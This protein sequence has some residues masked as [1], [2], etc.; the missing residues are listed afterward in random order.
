[1]LGNK[2][3][4]GKDRSVQ[5]YADFIGTAYWPHESKIKW[6]KITTKIG[7]KDLPIRSVQ[8]QVQDSS[9][10]YD[11]RNL[12]QNFHPIL[13]DKIIPNEGDKNVNGIFNEI[14]LKEKV[15]LRPKSCINGKI[16]KDDLLAIL[17]SDRFV[18][19]DFRL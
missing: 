2:V 3:D 13:K 11:L 18:F 8:V 6:K 10:P 19:L 15:L 1:M 7:A 4:I 16:S 14:G 9:D 5:L 17:N 12:D